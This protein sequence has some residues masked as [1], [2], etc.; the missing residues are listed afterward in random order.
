MVYQDH[1]LGFKIACTYNC[2]ATIHMERSYNIANDH[3]S[4]LSLGL[5]PR[6][7]L[8]IL[9][10]NVIKWIYITTYNRWSNGSMVLAKALCGGGGP[11]VE[12]RGLQ[13][14][15]TTTINQTTSDT[16]RP[17]IGP[18]VLIPFATKGH[19][20]LPDSTASNQ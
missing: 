8:H 6:R 11:G 20:S 15:Y 1:G 12:P 19:V 2:P 5:T 4:G 13:Q 9:N 14:F 7:I 10:S 17:Q 3:G 18:R 16:W